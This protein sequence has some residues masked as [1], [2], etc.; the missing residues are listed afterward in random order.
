[1]QSVICKLLNHK[2]KTMTLDELTKLFGGLNCYEDFYLEV[3]KLITDGVLEEVKSAGR[4]GLEHS[5]P[6]KYRLNKTAIKDDKK[7]IINNKI[8]KTHPL[9]ILEC[10]FDQSIKTF[11]EEEPFIDMIN[12]YI[13]KNGLPKYMLAPELSFVLTGDEKWIENG[14]GKI[15]LK[16]LGLWNQLKIERKSDPIAFAVNE[17]LIKR[18]MHKH[19]IVENKTPFLHL[20]DMLQ[21]S[22][23]NSVIYGQGWKIT[24]GLAMFERQYNFGAKHEFYYFGDV[25]KEGISIYLTLKER[26]GV[27]PAIEFYHALFNKSWS[28][29]K[30][31][32]RCS[33]EN[34]QLFIECLK[35]E[36][37]NESNRDQPNYILDMLSKGLYQPQEILSKQQIKEVVSQ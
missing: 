24:S 19:L 20:M 3:I 23:Y 27:K 7:K 17:E 22:Q 6:N 21:E 32:Q 36:M 13:C 11:R 12:D 14:P 8:L 25:D 28:K 10:Y 9:I 26:Y 29:G 4:N 18:Q 30:I 35:N 15:I 16:R 5:L 34:I 2:T 1:M 31:N 33:K 37:N